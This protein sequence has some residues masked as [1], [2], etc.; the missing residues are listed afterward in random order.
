MENE[1]SIRYPTETIGSV[2]KQYDMEMWT[3]TLDTKQRNKILQRFWNWKIDTDNQ[4]NEKQMVNRH[5]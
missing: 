3:G 5:I 1:F 2:T 4:G